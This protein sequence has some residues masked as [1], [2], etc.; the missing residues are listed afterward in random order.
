[1]VRPTV[2]LIAALLSASLPLHAQRNKG[3]KH[4]WRLDTYTLRDPKAMRRLGYKSFGPFPWG[5]D[6]S[7]ELIEQRLGSTVRLR[8][9]ETRH[10]RIGSSLPAWKPT[11]GRGKKRKA[12]AK[13]LRS[14]LVELAKTLPHLKPKRIKVWDPWLRLHVY[15]M[16]LERQRAEFLRRLGPQRVRSATA[17]QPG[18]KWDHRGLPPKF[19]VLLL[20]TTA[21]L[22]AYLAQFLQLRQKFGT[23]HVFRKNNTPLF[24]TTAANQL[25][26]DTALH[27]HVVFNV[28]H[29]FVR[30]YN[31]NFYR[32]PVWIGEGLAH[33][34][35]RQVDDR[36]SNY[37]QAPA[38]ESEMRYRDD[39]P[40]V[41]TLL[42]K[43]DNFRAFPKLI[44]LFEFSDLRF[45]DHIALWSRVA[46]L[47]NDEEHEFGLGTF[48]NGIK[49][50][51]T[52]KGLT[53]DSEPAL[54]RAQEKAL[55]AAW[56]RSSDEV[57]PAWK[58]CVLAKRKR[59]R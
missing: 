55:Q 9:V 1:M 29:L 54:L 14:E 49:G 21:Q 34:F 35:A 18:N 15:A 38:S 7:T 24:V 25:W 56:G 27:A 11:S 5:D 28:T 31:G 39:W 4:D 59:K 12:V 13:Q 36:W 58:K 50:L 51:R 23:R 17:N 33:Y 10:F 41:T 43:S 44:R 42:A 48:L 52:A 46:W 8:W 32:L 37:S 26:D 30:S 19:A 20:G 57:D 45:R 22:E 16:R 47:M 53:L 2:A 3:K 6:H 40:I